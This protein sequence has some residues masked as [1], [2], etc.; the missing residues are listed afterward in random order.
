MLFCHLSLLSVPF[1]P[2]DG[3]ETVA[4]KERYVSLAPAVTEILFALGLDEEIVGVTTFCNYP[5]ETAKKEKVGSFSDPSIEKIGSLQPT[6]IFA[7]GLEQA[8]V[9]N[10]LKQLGFTVYVSD[11]ATI[12]NLLQEIRTIGRLIH[13]ERSAKVLVD[14]LQ[15]RIEDVDARVK[16]IPQQLRKKVLME[17]WHTPLLVAGKESIVDELIRRAGGVNIAYDTPRAYSYFSAEKVIERNPDFIFTGHRDN[18]LDIMKKS[19]GW[20]RVN[21]VKENRVYSDISADI[22]LRPGPRL[23]DALEQMHNRLYSDEKK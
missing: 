16:Q 8:I 7:T 6:L 11:P 5:P 14:R 18:V 12:S 9:V 19:A 23:I 4:K 21:A 17:V 10:R 22:L 20:D 1:A 13:K 3:G 15:R 2:C